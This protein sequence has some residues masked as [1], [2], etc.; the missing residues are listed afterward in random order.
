MP[1]G[2]NLNFLV[3]FAIWLLTSSVPTVELLRLSQQDTLFHTSLLFLLLL[4]V[5]A[6]SFGIPNSLFYYSPPDQPYLFLSLDSRLTTPRANLH[7]FVVDL[8]PYQ[9]FHESVYSFPVLYGAAVTLAAC[10]LK[11]KKATYLVFSSQS[12]AQCLSLVNA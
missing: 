7:V 11:A 12:L 5:L 4:L 10:S 1:I 3:C 2:Y 6:K 8:A 9:L